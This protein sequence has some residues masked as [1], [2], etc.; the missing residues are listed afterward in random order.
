MFFLQSP[1][2]IKEYYIVS[3]FQCSAQPFDGSF[4]EMN[5]EI[6]TFYH[7]WVILFLTVL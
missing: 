2:Y 7:F 6:Y 1:V 4:L 3:R 5:Q